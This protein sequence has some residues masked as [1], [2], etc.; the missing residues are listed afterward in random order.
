MIY[1]E[2]KGVGSRKR[3]VKTLKE[4]MPSLLCEFGIKQNVGI[5]IKNVSKK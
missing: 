2:R 5:Q 3:V 4:T 1:K